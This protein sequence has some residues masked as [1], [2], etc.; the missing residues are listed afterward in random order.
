MFEYLKR[1]RQA[2]VAAEPF[3]QEWAAI[4]ERAVPYAKRLTPEARERL[5][6]LVNIFLDEKRFVGAGGLEITDEIRVTIAAQAVILVLGDEETLVYP[7]LGSVIVYPDA[8]FA[9]SRTVNGLVVSES[10]QVR[11]GE[12]WDRG[13]VVL[14][15]SAVKHGAQGTRDAHNVVFHEFAHQLDQE[16]GESDGAPELPDGMTYGT[17]SRVLGREFADLERTAATGR[18]TFLDEYGATNAAEFFAVAT[19]TFFERPIAL[20]AKKPELYAELAGF[21]RQDPAADLEAML[22]T[23]ET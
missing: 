11:L 19:E 8:Y 10:E 12:S 15:W 1:W 3:P 23:R 21:Y 22:P 13:T 18:K 5:E 6:D 9:E 17:W 16:M 2:K 4:I 7:E 14:A 20:R